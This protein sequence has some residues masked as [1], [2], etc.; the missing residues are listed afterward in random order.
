MSN[1]WD[2][3]WNPIDRIKKISDGELQQPARAFG[4]TWISE[5]VAVKVYLAGD[6]PEGALQLQLFTS[7]TGVL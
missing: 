4:R 7:T 3:V 1:D 5:R 6:A 2:E